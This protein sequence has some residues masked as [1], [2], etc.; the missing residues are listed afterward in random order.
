MLSNS[1]SADGLRC[2]P[3][4]ALASAPRFTGY[5]RGLALQ[6]AAISANSRASSRSLA[7]NALRF[8]ASPFMATPVC[9]Y[10]SGNWLMRA[11]NR[12]ND[13]LW[14]LAA[15]DDFSSWLLDGPGSIRVFLG[16]L[17]GT[18][19]AL[20][21]LMQGSAPAIWLQSLVSSPVFGGH[22]AVLLLVGSFLA[23]MTVLPHLLARLLP[24][25]T[26]LAILGAV[27]ALAVWLGSHAWQLILSAK[28]F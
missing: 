7:T 27:V 12:M 26:R 28:L 8:Y 15:L 22:G 13:K 17:A 24:A 14:P 21:L 19:V 6:S 5:P 9:R 25:L 4:N 20:L 2:S 23:G 11:L 16:A 1:S 10:G 18:I 3:W